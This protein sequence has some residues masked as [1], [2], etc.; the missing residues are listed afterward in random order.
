MTKTKAFT[1][2]IYYKFYNIFQS[3]SDF[4]YNT[5]IKFSESILPLICLLPFVS[6]IFVKLTRHIHE[7]I[8][9]ETIVCAGQNVLIHTSP[10]AAAAHCGRMEPARF[11]YPPITAWFEAA[12]QPHIS[13]T[14]VVLI[15]GFIYFSIF[16]AIVRA[17]LQK[18][19]LLYWRGPF[20]LCFSASGL[21][22]GNVS[23][24]FHGL[25]FFIAI[26]TVAWP[27]FL[28]PAIVF[29]GVL[30]PTFAV[31][32]GVFLFQRN[33]NMIR[34]LAL[35]CSAV[36]AIGLIMVWT[37]HAN[38][39]E[40]L[41]WLKRLHAVNTY[42]DFVQGHSFLVSLEM[43]GIHNP[44]TEMMLYVPFAAVMLLAGL[45]VI[46]H[47]DLSAKESVLL[48]IS[49]CLL[50]YPRL[51]DYDEYT[52]PFGLAVLAASFDL[53]RWPGGIWFRRILLGGCLIFALVGG[54]RGGVILYWFSVILLL[55]LATQL[56]IQTRDKKKLYAPTASL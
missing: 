35:G 9:A 36:V 8:D 18:D 52:L 6:G 31:Y 4:L 34:R 16:F 42:S 43:I 39:P 54:F 56:L 15:Y 55:T 28:W 46:H 2:N 5:P 40:F 41:Q 20:L 44:Q 26:G 50:L 10:Y 49:I 32:S 11:V 19:S 29:A 51:L 12:I 13:A 37:F 3:L 33:L 25:L 30:K 1:C 24:I 27:I 38:P 17:S 47:A 53:V 45:A 7:F 21:L 14:G 23:V 22:A 48:G